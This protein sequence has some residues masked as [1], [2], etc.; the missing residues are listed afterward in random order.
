M[1]DCAVAI[2]PKNC[3]LP[4]STVEADKISTYLSDE[5][6]ALTGA[7]ERVYFPENAGHVSAVLRA[8]AREH[9]KVTVSAAGTS[10]TGARVPL[11]GGRILSVERM[12]HATPGHIPEGFSPVHHRNMSFY[13]NPS[14]M[15][16]I[17]PVG[18]TLA[19]F[20]EALARYRLLYPPDPTEMSAMVGGTVATN[21]SGARSFH[22]EPTRAWV[23]GLDVVLPTGEFLTLKRG[24]YR[25]R[26]CTIPIEIGGRKRTL[27]I[28]PRYPVVSTKNAAG[29]Y[30]AE[31]M[32]LLDLFIG[33]E[34]I[35][36][37]VTAVHVNLAPL[38][39]DLITCVAFF[40]TMNDALGLVDT[41]RRREDCDAQPLSLEYFDRRA[42]DFLRNPFPGIPTDA[43]AAV[44][45]EFEYRRRDRHNPYPDGKTL[46]AWI[47]PLTKH[48]A[49]ADWSVSGMNIAKIKQFRH[50]LPEAVNTWVRAR[51][52]KLGT[53]MAVPLRDF[54]T[55]VD[56]YEAAD[57]CGVRTVFFGH[58]GDCHLHLNFL[59]ENREERTIAERQYLQLARL[60]VELGGTVSAEHGVGKKTIT[61]EAGNTI[62][63]LE[64]MLGR[65]GLNAIH[66]IKKALDPS[67]V[68]N[69]GNMVPEGYC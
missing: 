57:S 45:F 41:L 43:A 12:R 62:P 18:I 65:E 21:A 47:S 34:G 27:Q 56:A 38:P 55:M 52:G 68:L 63:Y 14:S 9:A 51:A 30:L 49:I 10:I 22:Y 50:A 11:S 31:N 42:L 25:A 66:G 2:E 46:A 4:S 17:T 26:G 54:R 35:L 15:Q 37:V 16:A 7:A 23:R 39:E 59:P 24:E 6:S 60:A 36:G 44:L 61:D 3:T 67:F 64:V 1:K 48:N 29:L 58:I 69:P 28:P 13:L 8:A 5:S 53:D 20:N 32:D 19:E 33:S 40:G